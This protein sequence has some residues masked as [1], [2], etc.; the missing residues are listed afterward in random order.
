MNL[1]HALDIMYSFLS[2]S[3]I[4]LVEEEEAMPEYQINDEE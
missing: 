1:K 3:Q 4:T 2:Q